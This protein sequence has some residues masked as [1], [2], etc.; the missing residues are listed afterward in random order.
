MTTPK[1]A[2]DLLPEIRQLRID[3]TDVSSPGALG[4]ISGTATVTISARTGDTVDWEEEGAWDSP[5]GRAVRFRNRLRWAL[6]PSGMSLKL[7]H[8][9]QGTDS[10]VWLCEFEPTPD[11]VLRTREPH[12]CGADTYS[13][14]L[15]VERS[16]FVLRWS[17]AGPRKAYRLIHSYGH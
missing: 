5:A 12:P 4:P 3:A 8:L 15:S 2:W 11:S 13:A 17:V 6:V 16:G 1:F 14:E 9:R 10:P 7:A